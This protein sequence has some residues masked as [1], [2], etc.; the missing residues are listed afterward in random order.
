MR[1]YIAATPVT[2]DG[3]RISLCTR[4]AIYAPNI[5]GLRFRYHCCRRKPSFASPAG[6]LIVTMMYSV[7]A[8]LN[9]NTVKNILINTAKDLETPAEI[10]R[11]PMDLQM[12]MQQ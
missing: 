10:I 3:I 8:G 2:G 1:Y 7:N 9:S 6:R 5:T 11:M 12:L 4:V